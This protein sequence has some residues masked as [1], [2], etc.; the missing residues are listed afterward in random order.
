MTFTDTPLSE[1]TISIW[2]KT[3]RKNGI[4]LSKDELISYIQSNPN[5]DDIEIKYG[6][7]QA[8]KIIPNTGPDHSDF[9]LEIMKQE[10][11]TDL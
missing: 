5:P 9:V 6:Q 8:M 3:L 1:K 10:G 4:E 2:D 11:V 7:S